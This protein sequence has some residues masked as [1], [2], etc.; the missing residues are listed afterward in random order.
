MTASN[1]TGKSAE[2]GFNARRLHAVL[3][4]SN[5]AQGLG[6]FAVI[7]A[8]AA[9]IR[10]FDIPAQH[11]GLVVTVYAIVYAITSPLL[12]AWTGRLKRRFVL[13]TG[14]LLIAIGAAAGIA[15]SSFDILL[16]GRVLMAIGG[17]LVTPVAGAIAVATSTPQNRGR[18]LAAVFAGLTI[19]Q[20]FGLPLGAWIV[21]IAGSRAAFALIALAAIAA[22]ALVWCHVP[23]NIVSAPT[24]LRQLSTIFVEPRLVVALAFIVFFIGGAFVFL[25]YLTPFLQNR[26]ALDG[27][28]LAGVLFVYG[29]AAVA[30]NALGGRLTDRLGPVKTLFI[31]CTVQALLLPALSLFLAPLSIAVALLALW[32]LS[33]WS[34][35]AAQQARLVAL[36]PARA[37][38][39]LALHSSC[40]F[41]G[42]SA[43]SAVAGL[44]LDVADDR[45]LGPVGGVLMVVAALSLGAV[46]KMGRRERAWPAPEKS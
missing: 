35:H 17:G 40:I 23:G 37:S 29:V 28:A 27:T 26:Y 19:A 42:V 10:E 20:A 7:G 44:I 25:T 11:A 3:A 24:G 39:L 21:D 31:L 41:L 38:M 4:A 2:A 33:A 46:E 34:V 43:G 36:D 15:A 30:G 22:A 18:V 45:W 6:A 1:A 12:V 16:A 8:M 5:F 9:L 13:A 14:L 32:S